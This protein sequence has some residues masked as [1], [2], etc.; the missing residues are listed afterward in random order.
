[1]C[2]QAQQLDENLFLTWIQWN[3]NEFA[4]P[5]TQAAACMFPDSG[6]SMTAL[7]DHSTHQCKISKWFL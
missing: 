4:F 2:L 5:Y 7:I 1:M 6:N 3:V